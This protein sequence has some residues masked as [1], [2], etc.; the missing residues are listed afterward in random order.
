MTTIQGAP[1]HT[2]RD[3]MTA[4]VV[5]VLRET[6]F[7]DLVRLMDEYRIS[8]VP[9]LDSRRRVLGLVSQ[10]DLLPKEANHDRRLGLR[11][12]LLRPD[13]AGKVAALVAGDLMSAPAVTI[14]PDET[15]AAAA[16]LMMRRSVRRLPVVDGGGRLIGVVSRGDLL[17]VFLRDD[18]VLVEDVRT[19]LER[20]LSSAEAARLTVTVTQGIAAISGTLT[21]SSRIPLV[22]RTVGGVDGVVDVAFAL[23]SAPRGP[24]APLPLGPLY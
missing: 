9:V 24:S 1:S 23:D 12:S 15:A 14:G 17:K 4:S 10:A 7:K 8:S 16:R 22:A 20:E 5:S 19:A 6:S 3:V 11:R 13:E 21:D 2:V 18:T